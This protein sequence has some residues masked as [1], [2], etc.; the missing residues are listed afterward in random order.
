MLPMK[1]EGQKAT[2]FLLLKNQSLCC[3]GVAPKI[4]EWVDVRMTGKGVKAI[5]DQP[6]TVCGIFHVGDVREN[7]DLVGIYRLDGDR[8]KG[9]G[10]SSWQTRRPGR[11]QGAAVRR[12]ASRLQISRFP[13]RLPLVKSSP[14][15]FG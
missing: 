13:F 12:L 1:F 4:T 14:T 3:Y 11:R 5:M 6:V 2:E 9:P 7:G 8:L 15:L 10:E